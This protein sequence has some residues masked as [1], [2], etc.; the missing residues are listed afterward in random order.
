MNEYIFYTC[1]GYTDPPKEGEEV[2]N[3]QVIGREHGKDWKDA[4]KKLVANRP[5]IKRCGF[6][7]EEFIYKQ[8]L[9]DETKQDIRE[10]IDYLIKDEQRHFQE[11]GKPE[12]HIYHT[13]LRLAKV[14][15]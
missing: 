6:D 10:V 7:I 15:E 1:E 4:R 9:T 5:W 8:L 3:C 13:L 11:C 12:K 14:I 2:E